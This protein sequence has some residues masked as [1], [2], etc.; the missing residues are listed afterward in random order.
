MPSP[1]PSAGAHLS[2]SMRREWIEI[3]P[4][5]CVVKLGASPSMRREWIEIKEVEK[6]DVVNRSVSLHAEG[7]D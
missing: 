7:V 6:S 3:F 4:P 5:G 1:K 2:P